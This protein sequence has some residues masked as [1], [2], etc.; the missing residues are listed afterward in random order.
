MYYIR[1][2]TKDDLYEVLNIAN[3]SL[4]ENYIPELFLDIH[5]LWPRGF[6]VA[7]SD[8]VVGF[9]AGSKY[10]RE[11]RILM[12]AVKDKYRGQGIGT[13]LMHR[14]M[15]VCRMEGIMSLRLEVRTTNLRAIE[16]YKNFGFTIISYVPNY[17][18][19]G[20]AAYIMWRMI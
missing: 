2:F 15:S 5:R 14:F 19:N 10:S 8:R 17:Y 4:T 9:I 18:T 3:E 12:L 7:V 6:L 11:A 20:D 1:E 16:F 13:A